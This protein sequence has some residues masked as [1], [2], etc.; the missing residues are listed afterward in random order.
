[1]KVKVKYVI[2]DRKFTIKSIFLMQKEL[3][4]G[5]DLLGGKAVETNR[6]KKNNSY[7]RYVMTL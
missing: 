2:T 1:M 4:S 5:I 7:F 6:W 3:A